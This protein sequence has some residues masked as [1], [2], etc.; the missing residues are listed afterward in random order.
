M[1][2]RD[3]IKTKPYT[4]P[5]WGWVGQYL[6]EVRIESGEASDRTLQGIEPEV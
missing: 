5:V 4:I 3:D 1:V 6:D 2:S